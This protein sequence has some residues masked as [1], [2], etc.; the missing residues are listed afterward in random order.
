MAAYDVKFCD[1]CR[2][3]IAAGQR[4]VREK[5]Y[6]PRSNT[7]DP[8]YRHFHA[9]AFGGREVSCWEKHQI[10]RELAR[11]GVTAIQWATVTAR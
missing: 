11:S 6:D 7:Q 10:E 1:Y 8:S 2:S 4:W 9:E 5:I 3:S